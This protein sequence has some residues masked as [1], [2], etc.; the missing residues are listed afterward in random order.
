[1]Q[2]L[3]DET[4]VQATTAPGQSQ[5]GISA[6]VNPTVAAIWSKTR[7]E[8]EALYKDAYKTNDKK[9][10]R[11]LARNDRYFL[12]TCVLNRK[13]ARNDWL[14]DRIRELEKDPDY[15]LDLWA[16]EHY[17][18]S[19]GTFAGII[20]EILKDPEITVG[21]FS[22]T[23]PIAKGFLRQI[24]QELETNK[25]LHSWF[26]EI[27]YVKTKDAPLW[28]EDEG[29]TV[30]RKSNPKEATVEAWGLVEGMPTGK[31]FKL[32]V[33]D[34]VVTEK[35]VTNPEMI[36][37]TTIA[38]ELSDNLGQIGGRRQMFGTR[39]HFGDTYGIILQRKAY[40]ERRYAAT[41][42]GTFDGKPVF[43]SDDE[44][45][46]KLATQSRST[47]AA[48]QLLNPLAGSETKF[49]IAWLN[50]C[51]WEVR[52]KKLN[53]YILMDPSKGR[54]AKSDYTAMAVV[55]VD[56][57][58]G[59]Y[60]LD[61]LRHRMPLSRRW[62][63]LKSAYQRWNRMDGIETVI[64]GYEQF[65]MQTDLE[66]FEDKMENEDGAPVFPI[67]ELAWPRE[68]GKSKEQRIERLEP[69]FRMGRFKFPGSF[70]IDDE[71]RLEPYNV[72]ETKAGQKAI[73][74]N[75]K[76]RVAVPILKKDEDGRL[77]D[78]MK[79][80]LEEYVFFPFAPYDDFL[81]CLSRI[82]DIDIGKPVHYDQDPNAANPI[83]PPIFMDG[84]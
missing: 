49:D 37:K 59:K 56:V 13:D 64:V 22:H 62:E 66:F 70:K 18:S 54:S 69:D 15:H 34:D 24:K 77:Y 42:D 17:K 36:K 83:V 40:K 35:S 72:L 45:Q 46:R 53:V 4:I 60:L 19:A 76:W 67:E 3:S 48:Q 26:P 39:Y 80:I 21:I 52:P 55:G 14:Y 41:H 23:R 43:L 8:A 5:L 12:L 10:L 16:R 7:L 29:I 79:S 63:V 61:G 75:E 71:G 50:N 2:G 58:G 57:G 65:G 81:D 47:I 74:D 25:V 30:K 1:M 44:W 28:S 38:W 78:L 68:G 11:F 27:F 6:K 33:Y 9:V 84:V 20:Q 82:Y 31:H 32:V 51:K 73:E